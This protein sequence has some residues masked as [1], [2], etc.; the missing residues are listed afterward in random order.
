MGVDTTCIGVEG[1]EVGTLKRLFGERN[2]IYVP[3][4]EELAK[5]LGQ[6]MIARV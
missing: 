1:C 5:E 3:R 2:G 6:L 4:I